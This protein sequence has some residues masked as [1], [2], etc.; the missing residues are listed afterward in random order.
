MSKRH[1]IRIYLD[2]VEMHNVNEFCQAHGISP[3]T[4]FKAGAQRLIKEDILERRVDLMTLQS[5]HEIQKG[6]AEP[7][8]DLIEMVGENGRAVE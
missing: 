8:D 6:L 4:L 5:W 1:Q 7:I 2:D 3:Q